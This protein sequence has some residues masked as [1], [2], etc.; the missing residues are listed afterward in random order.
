MSRLPVFAIIFIMVLTLPVFAE[1]KEEG[2]MVKEDVIK[3]SAGDLKITFIGHGTLMFSFGDKIIHVDPVS[4]E[5]DYSSMPR[6]D[7]IL[8]TH[9]HGDHLDPAAVKL[10]RKDGTQMVLTE[11]C[12]QR[13]E[14]GIVMKNGDVKTVAGLKIEAVPA[15]NIINKRQGGQPFHPKGI[16]NGHFFNVF[17]KQGLLYRVQARGLYI[18]DD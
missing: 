10:I 16:G 14:G 18:C 15:Y 2:S 9:E 12:A 3:T 8:V 5:G 7:L 4:G 11:I 1:D 17:C 13:I 6:A